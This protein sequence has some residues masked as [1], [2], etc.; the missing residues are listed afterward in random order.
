MVEFGDEALQANFKLFLEGRNI[1]KVDCGDRDGWQRWKR[2]N[3]VE[4]PEEPDETQGYVNTFKDIEVGDVVL[5]QHIGGE[6]GTKHTFGFGVVAHGDEFYDPESIPVD[7]DTGDPLALWVSWV[8]VADNGEHITADVPAEFPEEP[9]IAVSQEYFEDLLEGLG[10]ESYP[11][12]NDVLINRLIAAPSESPGFGLAEWLAESLDGDF[13]YFILKTGDDE[14]DD[15]PDSS[16]HFRENIPGCNQLNTAVPDV[17]FVYLEDGE[18][19]AVGSLG[20]V[21][22]KDR[23]GVSHYFAEVTQYHEIDPIPRETVEEQLTIDFPI[24]YG[25][26][27]IEESDYEH[28]LG[29]NTAR[30]PRAATDELLEEESGQAHLYRQALAHLVAGKNLVF[31]GP[32]GTGKTRAARKLSNAICAGDYSLVT[33]N[34]EWSNYQ[35]VGGY[36]PS[37]DGFEPQQGFLTKAAAD[38][39]QTLQQPADAHPTWLLIDELNRANLDEAFGDVFTLLDIDYRTSRKLSYAPNADDVP[40]PL[41][42]RILATMNTYDQAQLFSLGYAFRRR[43][44]FVRVPSLMDN[45]GQAP[46]TS[47]PTH[48]PSPPDLTP[49]SETTIDVVRDV[50]PEY[51]LL[52]VDDG[53]GVSAADVAVVLENL[54]TPT[55]L[56][57]TMEALDEHEEL[58][59]G[60]LDWLQTLAYFAQEVIKRDVVEIGQA[61]LIDAAKYVVAYQLLFPEQLDRSVLDQAVVS[62]LV[63]QFEHF[64]PELRRAETIDQDSH[65]AEDFQEIIDLANQLGLPETA[66]VLAA[67]KEDKRVLE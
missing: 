19:Y 63:P 48:D 4:Y 38:C 21:E 41:S 51:F 34:A 52:G 60:A 24:Q 16:Y 31:Y 54:A 36:A 58:R 33:A 55:Q 66:S 57:Q 49:G 56:Q 40:V 30:D 46:T 42:F 64:M 39:Q 59:T 62:Y 35:V 12:D 67:A 27:K 23:D 5:A 44:A 53:V 47:E 28:I 6:E 9:V 32:P 22:T 43:F 1:Y 15:E 29:S 50:I 13:E 8:T 61:L 65:A 11:P 20:E 10:G 26:I 14:Y 18:F 3:R 25:I 2:L 17:R 45:G 7:P 37:E